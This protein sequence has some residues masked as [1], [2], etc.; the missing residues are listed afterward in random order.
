MSGIEGFNQGVE[1]ERPEN[2]STKIEIDGGWTRQEN[3]ARADE[4]LREIARER[5]N[6]S[7]VIETMRQNDFN[8]FL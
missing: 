8:F 4:V 1:I 6:E 3:L 7:R 5:L 2:G